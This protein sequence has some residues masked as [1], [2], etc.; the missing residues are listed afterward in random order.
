MLYEYVQTGHSLP[1]LPVRSMEDGR[2]FLHD[3]V[4]N[5]NALPMSATNRHNELPYQILRPNIT[6]TASLPQLQLEPS[7]YSTFVATVS[8]PNTFMASSMQQHLPLPEYDSLESRLDLQEI[9]L[10]MDTDAGE[11]ARLYWLQTHMA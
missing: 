1:A 7:P 4:T 10:L 9:C 2:P 5:L 3:I 11:A 6:P 8:D